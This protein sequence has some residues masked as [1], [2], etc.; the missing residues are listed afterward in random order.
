M[1]AK[2]SADPQFTVNVELYHKSRG[3]DL[4]LIFVSQ[5][6][7]RTRNADEAKTSSAF[8]YVL[9]QIDLTEY[10]QVLR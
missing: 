3:K 4:A 7:F 10:L 1:G 5:I 9:S 2:S 6:A 8:G